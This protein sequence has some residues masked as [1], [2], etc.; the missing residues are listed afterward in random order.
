MNIVQEN[1]DTLN[2][3]LKVQLKPEDYRPQVDEAI[4]KYKKKA[5][6]PGFRPG[7]V[8]ENLIR[9]MYGK[10][11]LA[12]ELNKI[13]AD[14]VDKFIVENNLQVLGNPLPKAENDI[15]INWDQPTDFEFSFDM[16]L[17]P[18][19]HLTLPPAHSFLTYDIQVDEKTIDEEIDKLARRY[20]NYTSPEVTDI[21]SSVYGTFREVDANGELVENGHSNQAF[22]M[23]TKVA[24]E[25]TRNKFVGVKNGDAIIFNPVTA[26]RVEEEVKYLLG[27]KEGNIQDYSKDYSFTIE[28]INRVEKAEF[29]Q[30]FFDQVY[31]ENVVSDLAGFREK[32]RSEIAQGYG[33]EAD[34][35]LRHEMEDVLLKESNLNL[36]DEF[37]KRWLKHSNEKITDEQLAKEYHQY[38]RDLKWKLIE[39]KIYGDQNMQLTKEEI[40]SYARNMIIDQYLRYGQA[41]MLDEEKLKELTERYLKNQESVQR[42]VESLSGRKVFEYLNQIVSKDVKNVSHDEFVEIMSRHHHH[43]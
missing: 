15:D 3:V 42:V 37:L 5:S 10:S 4:K 13:V 41:H 28:R 34:N 20:G 16:A 1:I 23:I 32:V 8:P 19:V 33:Y 35:A 18:E 11:V 27:I 26:I 36:P 21:D 22:M 6:M 40:E 29:N 7:H 14:S 9:K 31:G 24:D 30:A 39:N 17:A 12:D 2:A 38:A 43:H 25:A